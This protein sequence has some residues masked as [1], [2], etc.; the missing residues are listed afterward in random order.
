MSRIGKKTIAVPGGVKVEQKG[1]H[2]KI[3]G[4]K[5]TLELDTHPEIEVNVE[6]NKII[7]SNPDQEDRRKKALHGTVRALLNNMVIGAS[8]GFSKPMQIFGTGYNVKEQGGKLVLNVG[9]CHPVELKVPKSVNVE[10]K[11]PATRGNDVPALFTLSG[12]NKQELGQFAAEV[13]KVRP[14]EPY[15]GKGIRY[16]DEHVIRKVGKAL[17]A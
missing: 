17:G 15:Q 1:R 7:V 16:T 6:D 9:Y 3:S 10:I 4:P 12:P 11:T 5:G 14:P 2:F 13:R 8:K